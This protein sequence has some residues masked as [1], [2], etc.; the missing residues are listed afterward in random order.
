MTSRSSGEL[1]VR[2]WQ[3]IASVISAHLT[4][5]R[6]VAIL[7]E[8]AL[9]VLQSTIANV[10][11]APHQAQTLQA[12]VPEF[13]ER[14]DAMAP[15][16]VRGAGRVGRGTTEVTATVVRLILREDLLALAWATNTVRSALLNFAASHL[17]TLLPAYSGGQPAQPTTLAHLL[18]AVISPLERA[19]N[20][21]N[22]AYEVVNRS[23][24]GAVSLAST[25]LEI[26]P[27]KTG[28]FLGFSGSIENSFDA[29]SATDHVV[30]ALDAAHLAIA[31]SSRLL[32]ELSV[33][34]R[35]QPDAI[36]FDE[37]VLERDA[38]L[39]QSAYPAKWQAIATEAK[40]VARALHQ[41]RLALDSIS[42][43]PVVGPDAEEVLGAS[44]VLN[45]VTAL[46]ERLAEF[47]I[48]H[49]NLN[50][51]VLA[52]RAGKGL[53]TSSDLAD[54][55]MLEEQ[56]PPF[57]AQAIANRVIALA[58]EEGREASGITPELIDS[59]A[60][61]ILGRDLRVEFET[62]SR[63]LAPRRFIERRALP[64]SPAPAAMRI[65]L[66]RASTKLEQDQHWQVNIA[67]ALSEALRNLDVTLATSGD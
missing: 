1:H 22:L 25:S 14:M 43:G 9:I 56:L 29:V 23:P 33:W 15:P 48:N 66:E 17:V 5:L 16:E 30:A 21:L 58:R 44:I 11:Q 46:Q 61:L 39:P 20:S 65:Y 28:E 42:F 59:A 18:G 67:E 26:E 55:L 62:I 51:A 4:M 47:I 52:N 45:Q 10:R 8:D 31:P 32:E 27:S 37:Q 12:M 38:A 57:A 36:Q 13:D 64:G 53:I 6:D 54:F 34:L 24:M 60:L 40:R 2:A 49:L 3:A 41:A 35:I 63:Y 19:A 50:R 7:D